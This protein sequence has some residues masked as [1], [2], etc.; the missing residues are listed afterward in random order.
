[1]PRSEV[2][3]SEKYVAI[4]LDNSEYLMDHEQ[5]GELLDA[6]RLNPPSNVV[7]MA[8]LEEEYA[9]KDEDSRN[10]MVR[11]LDDYTADTIMHYVEEVA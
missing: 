1:M 10:A 4:K 8:V 11:E 7:W 3:K 2:I 9:P 5:Y 6:I